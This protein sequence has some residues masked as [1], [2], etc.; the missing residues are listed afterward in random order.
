[1]AKMLRNENSQLFFFPV[2]LLVMCS[3]HQAVLILIFIV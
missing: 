3:I 2:E 1:L